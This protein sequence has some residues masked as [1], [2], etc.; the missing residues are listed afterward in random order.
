[1]GYHLIIKN[2]KDSVNSI[3]INHLDELLDY[4]LDEDFIIYQGEPNWKP[5]KLKE[6]E[7]YRNYTLDWFRAGIK[8]Q[9]LFKEQAAIEGFVLEE[10]NQSQESFKIYTN[11]ADGLIKRGDFIVRNAQ[12]VEIEVKCRKFY[13][14]KKSP[15]FYF[16]IKDFEKHKKMME[17]TGCPVIIAVY[18]KERD[19]PINDSL[20][21]ISMATIISKCN[22][23]EKSPH[24]DKNV[25]TAFIIPLSISTPGFDV[26]RK[27]RN[28]KRS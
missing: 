9:K 15:F 26:L 16:S 3:Y 23:L 18:E 25:G 13:G 19:Y 8:A 27:F 17:V 5:V 4:E 12:Q 2:K 10:I 7:E 28:S 20:L 21:M 1:M 11:V 24:P 6:V 14:S 22:D